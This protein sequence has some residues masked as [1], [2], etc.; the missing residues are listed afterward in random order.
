LQLLSQMSKQA[1]A[2]KEAIELL[3]GH[4]T[5]ERSKTSLDITFG[6]SRLLSQRAQHQA[7]TVMATHDYPPKENR[8]GR[9]DQS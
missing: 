4:G 2:I 7:E 9:S 3:L 1:E 6:Q 8:T 5:A